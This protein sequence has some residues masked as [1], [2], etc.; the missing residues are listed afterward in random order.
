MYGE[1][2]VI[3]ALA[4]SSYG[5]LLNRKREYG[6]GSYT[7]LLNRIE[8][9]FGDSAVRRHEI[10]VVMPTGSKFL[11]FVAL[12]ETWELTEILGVVFEEI[13][14]SEENLD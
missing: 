9:S 7:N 14:I 10:S 8:N 3:A 6:K 1:Y 5:D 11:L 13:E 12:F 4:N 2:L